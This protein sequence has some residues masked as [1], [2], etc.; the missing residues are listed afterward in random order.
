MVLGPILLLQTAVASPPAYSGRDGQLRVA[1]PRLEASVAIDGV[2]DEPAW[3]AA[4][5]LTGFSE[6]TPVDGRPA[7]DSTEILVWYSAT[8]I[9][10]GVRAYAPRG[11]VH[12]TLADRDKIG[13]DD[14]VEILLDTFNDH[15]QAMVFGVNPLG[16]QSDGM[17]NEGK[18][19]GVTG[20][21]GT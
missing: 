4:A 3:R 15:R 5:R 12:A 11:A 7:E 19:A 2:L 9:Y 10:F 21:G 13:A 16:V 17:L 6:Y 1:V 18:S 14:Y 8:A 20:F